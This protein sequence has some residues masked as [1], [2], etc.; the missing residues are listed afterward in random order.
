MIAT[1]ARTIVTA[2]AETSA[3]AGQAHWYFGD[4]S[5]TITRRRL[6]SGLVR[7]RITVKHDNTHRPSW[8]HTPDMTEYRDLTAEEADA[9]FAKVLAMYDAR[10][11][12]QLSTY[13]RREL[14]LAA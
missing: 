1:D 11:V 8:L 3:T 12:A 6:T 5:V 13:A 10:Y 7:V 4:Y 14:S 2:T 9:Q